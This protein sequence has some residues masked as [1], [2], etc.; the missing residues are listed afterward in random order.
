MRF[1]LH[2][3]YDTAARIAGEAC[4]HLQ[5]GGKMAALNSS[6]LGHSFL[7]RSSSRCLLGFEQP[8]WGVNINEQSETMA[9]LLRMSFP[10]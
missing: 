3:K 6:T 4:Q 5:E 7:A 1:Q 9:I 8:C 2:E 10:K